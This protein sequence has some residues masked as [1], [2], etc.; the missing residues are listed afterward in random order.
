MVYIHLEPHQITNLYKLASMGVEA[1]VIAYHAETQK[2]YF[3]PFKVLDA[4][5][6]ETQAQKSEEKKTSSDAQAAWV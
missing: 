5:G 3:Y 2:F 1:L 4:E 6:T